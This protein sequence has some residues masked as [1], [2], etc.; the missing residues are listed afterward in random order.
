MKQN[1]KLWE[2]T[3]ND[4]HN[5]LKIDS[6]NSIFNYYKLSPFTNPDIKFPLN[7]KYKNELDKN[8][9]L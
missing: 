8:I 4:L 3:L 1:K 2:K 7:R 6:F 5:Q 9:L